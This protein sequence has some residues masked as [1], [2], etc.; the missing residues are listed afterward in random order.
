MR[1][2]LLSLIALSFIGCS[3]KQKKS[4]SAKS[5]KAQVEKEQKMPDKKNKKD[6]KK[7]KAKSSASTILCTYDKATRELS[8]VE[9]GSGCTVEYKRDGVDSQLGS[10]ASG[11]S[12]C[13]DLVDKTK[14]K[15]EAAGFTCK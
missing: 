1:I 15:L 10:G 11:S 9:S 14:A 13:Q 12:F 7:A 2:L 4:D 3:S 6:G 8:V 5:D